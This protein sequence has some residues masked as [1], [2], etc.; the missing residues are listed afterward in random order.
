MLDSDDQLNIET[1]EPLVNNACRHLLV[2]D[3]EM[4]N[5]DSIHY[6]AG[7]QYDKLYESEGSDAVL[8]GEES[9]VRYQ[10]LLAEILGLRD[11]RAGATV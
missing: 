4:I 11:E 9:V 10:S 3:F 6:S 7:N 2:Q 8:T 1:P 5:G